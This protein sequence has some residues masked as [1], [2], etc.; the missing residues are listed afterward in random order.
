MPVL[1]DDGTLRVCFFYCL[2]ESAPEIMRYLIGNIQAPA[3]NVVF[4]DPVNSN[5]DQ[6]VLYLRI[7]CIPLGHI[8][9]A[10]E[11]LVVDLL[12]VHCIA[13]DDKPIEIPGFL[14]ILQH[15]LE[16]FTLIADM[17]EHRVNHHPDIPGM[18]SF[19]Q[20]G[21]IH[22]TAKHGIHGK[23]ILDIVLMVADR[24]ENWGQVQ[25]ID[26]QILQIRQFLLN[27]FQIAACKALGGGNLP[28][29]KIDV[30]IILIVVS[31]EESIN[32]ELIEA[33]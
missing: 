15:I 6:E 7:G 20:F 22:I 28:P 16:L 4:L 13:M 26:A 11:A 33:G 9:A 18:S 30:G 10:G 23:V 17:V 31:P 24:F 12:L 21:K 3:V 25:G 32:K 8:V 14:T 19:H 1:T 29:G 2:P 27:A 5:A